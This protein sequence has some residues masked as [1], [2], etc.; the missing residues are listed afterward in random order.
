MIPYLKR[1]VPRKGGERAASAPSTFH[2]SALHRS[3]V[4]LAWICSCT[5]FHAPL[6]SV[7]S[8]RQ[9]KE[10]DGKK[11]KGSVQQTVATGDG[12]YTR[13]Q[14]WVTIRRNVPIDHRCWITDDNSSTFTLFPMKDTECSA[15]ERS[16]F[17]ECATPANPVAL[18]VSPEWEQFGVFS[19][20]EETERMW[21][22][23]TV[24]MRWW[25]WMKMHWAVKCDHCGYL[26]TTIQRFFS[27]ARI[28]IR[29]VILC[30]R[31]ME[32]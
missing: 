30:R 10:E 11:G 27:E 2:P 15:W 17:G 18:G 21:C 14:L 19:H 1:A 5:S 32:C 20:C 7:F 22:A 8:H 31:K 26:H 3:K 24:G 6:H 23:V 12:T 28:L 16:Q 4:K 25:R 9:S 13:H 29:D